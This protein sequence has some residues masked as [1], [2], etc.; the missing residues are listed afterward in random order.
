[1]CEA[2]GSGYVLLQPVEPPGWGRALGSDATVV[3]AFV[4]VLAVVAWE[5]DVRL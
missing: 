5:Q 2:Y 1:M 4:R 3:V